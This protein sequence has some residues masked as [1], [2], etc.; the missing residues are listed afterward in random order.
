MN[1]QEALII[2]KKV[3]A[4]FKGTLADHEAIQTA[5]KLIEVDLFPP[6]PLPAPPVV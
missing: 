4:D 5:V 2:V 6:A 3:C 1:T